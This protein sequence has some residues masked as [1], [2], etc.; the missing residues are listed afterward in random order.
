MKN[1]RLMGIIGIAV[2]VLGIGAFFFLKKEKTTEAPATTLKKKLSLPTN[3][4]PVEERPYV[5]IEPM[6][7]GK[8][9]QIHVYSLEKEATSMEYE[10]EYQAGT[11]LQGAFGEVAITEL[12]TT[13]KI[14]L[15]SCSAGGACT[16]HEDVKGGS[17]LTRY[18]G[19]SDPYALKSDWKY[20]D[21][22]KKEMAFSSKD[23]KFQIEGKPLAQLR[24]AVIFNTPGHPKKVPGTIV[25]DIYSL[26]ASSTLSG[27]AKL[28]MR[29]TE[30]GSL[31]I[32]S[33]NGSE[34]KTTEGTVD[35]KMI[36]ATV[37]L[38]E[39]YVVVK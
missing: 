32:A 36:T 15:G 3:V 26:T 29:A 37:N 4:I 13:T 8:N 27:E 5:S 1:K 25:S 33:W 30:E 11:L 9:L 2:L 38:A 10:L 19:G 39:L 35:G 17:L 12:P 14:L 24:Y 22:A 18:V 23:A 28:T 21:N 16:Y 6:A 31:K 20:I 34:W 7:D